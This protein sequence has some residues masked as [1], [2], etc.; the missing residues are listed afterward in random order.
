MKK[1][2]LRS[3]V[4]GLAATAIAA[5]GFAQTTAA[6]KPTPIINKA[7]GIANAYPSSFAMAGRPGGDSL[8]RS[9]PGGDSLE[10]SLPGGDS[11]ARSLPGGD[12]IA[13]SLPGGDSIARGLPGGDSIARGLPGGDSLERGLPGGDSLGRGLPGGD[14]LGRN[15]ILENIEMTA[16]PNPFGAQTVISIAMAT[17]EHVTLEVYSLQGVRV[18]TLFDGATTAGVRHHFEFQP[19]TMANGVYLAR[20][21][22]GAGE[23]RHLKLVLNR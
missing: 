12:S 20:V 11:I 1:F 6:L 21:T 23:V 18:A 15:T 14:S 8:E 22:T 19:A 9:L 5:T 2:N 4:A 13:R 7:G 3:I 10:R 16:T 17:D